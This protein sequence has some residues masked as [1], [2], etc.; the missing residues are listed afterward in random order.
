[1]WEKFSLRIGHVILA[2]MGDA[3]TYNSGT[4]RRRIF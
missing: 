3:V 4:D 1:M 2:A